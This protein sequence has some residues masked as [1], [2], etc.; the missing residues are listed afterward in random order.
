MKA[1]FSI[2]SLIIML[3]IVEAVDCAINDESDLFISSNNGA[4]ENITH[5]PTESPKPSPNP[6]LSPSASPSKSLRPSSSPTGSWPPTTVP[7]WS[8]TLLRS[9]QPTAS[10]KPSPS[11]STEPSR[12]PSSF[13]TIPTFQPSLA[14]TSSVN[15]SLIPSSMPTSD[16]IEV[17]TTLNITLKSLKY[18]MDVFETHLFERVTKRFIAENLPPEDDVNSLTSMFMEP[19]FAIVRK[20]YLTLHNEFDH[21]LIVEVEMAGVVGPRPFP[22]NFSIHEFLNYNILYGFNHNL[23]SFEFLVY[24]ALEDLE[25][26]LPKDRSEIIEEDEIGPEEVVPFI[27]LAACCLALFGTIYLL[28]KKIISNPNRFQEGNNMDDMKLNQHP[29][30]EDD[31]QICNSTS[32]SKNDETIHSVS[33]LID[34]HK[35]V[36]STYNRCNVGDEIEA[37][38]V[39]VSPRSEMLQRLSLILSSPQG[40]A[41]YYVKHSDESVEIR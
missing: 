11:P 33:P 14:P 10:P 38:V 34:V 30:T 5:S 21:V 40:R 1:F 36:S 17:S 3:L 19:S 6:T 15:P 26:Y 35:C 2:N 18:I 29:T 39:A 13:P 31:Y 28:C 24:S 12:F 9:D 16:T 37:V 41:K 22:T 23:T 25:T 27:F 32:S 20:Q 8:P 7:S 4:M